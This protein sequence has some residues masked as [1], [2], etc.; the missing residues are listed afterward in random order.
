MT[1]NNADSVGESI[2]GGGRA[3]VLLDYLPK[4]II[5]MDSHPI[6]MY[7]SNPTINLLRLHC[8]VKSFLSA[9]Q[10][11]KYKTQ[12]FEHPGH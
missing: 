11:P 9:L 1:F 6:S 10:M 3:Q 2:R 4:G 12:N 8:V 7:K 5:V